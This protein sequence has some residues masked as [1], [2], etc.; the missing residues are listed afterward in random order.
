M[1]SSSGS[2]TA[3]DAQYELDEL[4]LLRSV[5]LTTAETLHV[6]SFM[7]E[8]IID[9]SDQSLRNLYARVADLD[10]LTSQGTRYGRLWAPANCVSVN[11]SM[12]RRLTRTAQVSAHQA[13]ISG[14]R[15]P[16]VTRCLT[17]RRAPRRDIQEARTRRF[18]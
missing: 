7:Y 5:L 2:W 10:R 4:R 17:V 15:N 1:P 16:R 8:P 6:N 9:M 14:S 18:S 13:Y 11:K 3:R 12:G